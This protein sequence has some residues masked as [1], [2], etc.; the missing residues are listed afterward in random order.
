MVSNKYYCMNKCLK[1]NEKLTKRFQKLFCSSSCA[2]SHNNV[3]RPSRIKPEQIASCLNCSKSIIRTPGEIKKGHKIYCS[4]VCAVTYKIKKNQIKRQELFSAGK[5]KYR[6]KLRELVIERD[7]YRCTCCNNVTWQNNPIPL[8][9]DHVD[10]NASNN[11]PDNL[12]M[13]CLN[14]DA[15]SP[16]FGNKNRGN[17]RRSL[18]LR[19]WE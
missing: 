7:G 17:G 5:L 2:A 4:N 12:R 3:N 8:W 19:P 11:F 15:L 18:G 1:C 9:L 6:S 13:V 16:T 10:G 14:C